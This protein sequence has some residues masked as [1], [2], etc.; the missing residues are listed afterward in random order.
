MKKF[1]VS[2]LISGL[3]WAC[4]LYLGF[5]GDPETALAVTILPTTALLRVNLQT[6]EVFGA[7]QRS[8]E[9]T[10]KAEA[11]RKQIAAQN[12]L[13]GQF[14]EALT[15]PR[16]DNADVRV[17]WVDFCGQAAAD[18]T[19]D[20]YC[21]DLDA[22]VPGIDYKDYNITGCITDGFKLSESTFAGSFADMQEFIRLNQVQK[23][24][25]LVNLL[26]KKYLLFLAAN[27]AY[28]AGGQY[29]QASGISTIPAEEYENTNLVA[30][31]MLDALLSQMPNPFILD[32]KN[33]WMT[34]TQAKF[35]RE[36][37]DGR[38]D[39][40]RADFFDITFDPFGFAAAALPDSTFLVTPY[41]AR[42][43]NKN[44][45]E[46]ATPQY[47]PTTKHDKY[48]IN[49]PGFG[50]RVDVLHQRICE[51]EKLNRFAHVWRYTLHH[52]FLL[53]PNGCD[54]GSGNR[55]NGIIEYR[56]GAE[57]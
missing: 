28:N 19:N 44:Y 43:V 24:S 30:K 18:C 37:L 54:L 39:A 29:A 33:L 34:W 15:N 16:K 49:I 50:I 1:H 57:E 26:N 31:I 40:N 14:V 25:N 51:S 46:N 7:T 4:A 21:G 32:G 53:N 17:W 2:Y 13:G 10:I 36:N 8:I 38:G 3:L 48:S 42:F 27:A 41:A 22:A 45:Y 12:A 11:L 55:V 6:E 35:N 56:K 20:T 47:D 5:S 52:D 23:I 9:N